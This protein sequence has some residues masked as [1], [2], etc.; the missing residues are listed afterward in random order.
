MP[1]ASSDVP[2]D[3][4][5]P[6]LDHQQ[7]VFDHLLS[8][9]R[10]C[11]GV[12]RNTLP[13]KL[14]TNCLLVGPTGSGKTFLARAVASE[15]A[16]PIL[17]LS[18]SNWVLL[19]C[20]E[21]GAEVT[22]RT[23]FNFLSRN[24]KSSG[25]IIFLDEL[26]K[27]AGSSSWDVHLRV[28]I[29]NLLDLSIPEGLKDDD[30]DL[31]DPSSCA[32]A[33]EVLMNRT[34]IIAAGAFQHI[35][36]QKTQSVI[37]FNDPTTELLPPTSQELVQTLPRELVNRFAGRFSILPP[38]QRADYFSMLKD[39]AARV[40][41]YLRETFLRL[42]SEKISEAISMQQGCRFLEE[43]MLNT[44]LTERAHLQD[45]PKTEPRKPETATQAELRIDP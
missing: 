17:I 42:G 8:V 23:I 21:R 16:V 31:F 32:A 39:T 4:P 3:S 29:F 33:R 22:W 35:W 12:Q 27:I 6:V 1:L 14:K 2:S 25:L 15:L 40:P 34:L 36:E 24:T 10:V 18:A 43:L 45:V 44:I 26:D 11:F 9:G 37:G 28:E 7:H 5:P 20:S 41:S 13:V 30:G 19:G 38:L